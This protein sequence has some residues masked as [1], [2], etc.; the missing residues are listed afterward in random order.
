MNSGCY[1]GGPR[2]VA[3]RRVWTCRVKKQ[4][5]SPSKK[6]LELEWPS[7]SCC[8]ASRVATFKARVECK[9]MRT[10]CPLTLI[11][12]LSLNWNLSIEHLFEKHLRLLRQYN[13]LWG[14][15]CILQLYVHAWVCVI[16]LTY[17]VSRRIDCSDSKLAFQ[18]KGFPRPPAL[19]TNFMQV[20]HQT[21][22]SASEP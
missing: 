8:R 4:S 18:G 21:G 13:W 17:W 7:L 1:I 22:R 9:H 10:F 16:L 6:A 12:P 14:C 19:N 15:L 2:R 11:D 20:H 5:P 3:G